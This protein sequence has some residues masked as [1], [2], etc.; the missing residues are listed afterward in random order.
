MFCLVVL[1]FAFAGSASAHKPSDS[2]LML[3]ARPGDRIVSGQW[4]I[5]LRDLDLALDLDINRD[6]AIDW[7]SA[8][9]RTRPVRLRARAP[10][11][12]RDAEPC[13]MVP[14]ELLVDDHSDGAYAVL[15]F[16]A[17]CTRPVQRLGVAYRLLFDLDASHRGLLRLDAGGVSRSAVLSP[18]EKDPRRQRS[19]SI[20]QNLAPGDIRAVR[21]RWHAP[22]L[23]RL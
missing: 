9:A 8:H 13:A 11:P 6:G 14:G 15:R 2:Y 5:A 12:D 10:G 1:L 16:S 4:D 23:D 19:S 3:S 7:R 20:W 18:T 21:R 22:H 17:Q